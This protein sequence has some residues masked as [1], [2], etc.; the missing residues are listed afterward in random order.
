[1]LLKLTKYQKLLIANIPVII[2]APDAIASFKSL[3][4]D[5]EFFHK[6]EEFVPITSVETFGKF[7]EIVHSF[8]T[9]ID[10]KPVDTANLS[11]LLNEEVTYK[12]TLVHLIGRD[13]C[14]NYFGRDTFIEKYLL[15]FNFL[16]AK[17]DVETF[18]SSDTLCLV[19]KPDTSEQDQP[20]IGNQFSSTLLIKLDKNGQVSSI[21]NNFLSVPLISDETSG[22]VGKASKLFEYK[23]RFNAYFFLSFI[24]LWKSF[25]N[26]ETLSPTEIALERPKPKKNLE[27]DV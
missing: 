4:G 9:I 14:L 15:S 1:M 23:R 20:E 19:Y 8:K 12:D 7:D 6:K 3:G 21:T 27:K 25:T 5:K 24:G 26:K 13:E 2:F 22:L 17:N 10:K 16:E 18:I 11:K